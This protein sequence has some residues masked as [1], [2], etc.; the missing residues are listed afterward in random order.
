MGIEVRDP[1]SGRDDARTF[2]L[3]VRER[4]IR[5]LL[6]V[7]DAAVADVDDLPPA[8]RSLIASA[9][10]VHVLTPSLPGRLAWLADDVD[11]YRHV[12]DERLDTVLG[13]MRALDADA[14]GLAG[15]GSIIAVVAD[16]VARFAPDHILLALRSAAH[17]N[18]QERRLFEHIE[19]R[20][21]LPLTTYAVDLRGH[22]PTADGPLLLCYDGSAGAS[23]AIRHAGRLFAGRRALVLTVWE[24]TATAVSGSLGFAGE[25]AGMTDFVVLDRSAAEEGGRIAGEGVRV[26]SEAGLMAEP[27][28][29]EA[30]GTVWET[31][32]ELA[33]RNAAATIVM[34]SRGLTGL[35]SKLLGSVSSAVVHHADRPTLIVRQPVARE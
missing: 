13:H 9:A 29:V 34:G 23:D 5:R 35:R 25:S 17:A 31:I 28:S 21:G 18:W 24:P 4:A 27:R 19:E 11:R 32:V 14:R 15:R 7:A 16:A 33:D 22:T 10:E 30:T 6:F 26:A 1:R 12:A 20:F 8:V 2:T 3:M